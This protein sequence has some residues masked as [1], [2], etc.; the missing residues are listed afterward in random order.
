MALK[1]VHKPTKVADPPMMQADAPVTPKRDVQPASQ[2]GPESAE[3]TSEKRP[4]KETKTAAFA[5]RFKS[6]PRLQDVSPAA[7]Y[8]IVSRKPKKTIGA[9]SI[10]AWDKLEKYKKAEFM[11]SARHWRGA[12]SEKSAATIYR[13][14]RQSASIYFSLWHLR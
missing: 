1:P 12:L 6:C 8:T 14:R 3:P 7:H 4:G 11:M 5:R 13:T 2:K 9:A 10:E